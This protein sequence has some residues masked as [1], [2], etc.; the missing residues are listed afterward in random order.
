MRIIDEKLH[1]SWAARLLGHV[2]AYVYFFNRPFGAKRF[3]TIHRY[4]VDVTR[5][6]ALLFGIGIEALPA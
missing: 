1:V 6:L 5:G 4:S 2:L 3:Q